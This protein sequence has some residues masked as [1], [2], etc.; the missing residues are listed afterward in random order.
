MR[1]VVLVI[2]SLFCFTTVYS[3]STG[4]NLAK[5]KEFLTTHTNMSSD[6]LL[7]QYDHG[8]FKAKISGKIAEAR[9]LDSVFIKYKMT[10]DE[11]G[12]LS[13]NGFTVTER[14]SYTNMV[15]AF[16]DVWAKDLP[17]FISTDAVLNAFHLSY[18]LIL[19]E[20]ELKFLIPK[21]EEFLN[22]LSANIGTLQKKYSSESKIIVS[23]KDLDIYLTVARKLLN[24]SYEP[25]FK[26]N[27]DLLIHLIDNVG[28]QTL[29]IEPLF[30]IADR[31]VDYSQF[32][33]R[34]HYTEQVQ[35]TKYFKTMMWLGRIEI[36]L[37]SP[38]EDKTSPTAFEDERRQIII[39]SLLGEL[40]Q[41][42]GAQQNYDEIEKIISSFVGEQDN[43]TL[44]QLN[45]LF[46][47]TKAQD[48][49]FFLK[50]ENV[51]LFQDY[52]STQPFAEQKIL[53]QVLSSDPLSPD[54][55]KP[56]S[57]FLF[58]GQRFVI[59][60][61]V[62]GNVV[63][64]K[65]LFNNQKITRLLPS[66]L[67]VLF[68]L[69]NSSVAQLLK[70]ELDKY[71]Y[72]TNL[73]SLR[74][75]VDSYGEDFWGLSIYNSWLNG[76]RSLNPPK[77]R[78]DLPEFMQTA[79][80]WQQKMNTQLAS[81]AE[82]RH[83]NIL[84]AKQ[85]YSSIVGCS[86]P[87]SYVEPIPQFFSAMKQIAKLALE[88][89]SSLSIDLTGPKFYFNS[90]YSTIDTLETIAKK[91]LDAVEFSK[92]EKKFLSSVV[93]TVQGGCTTTYDG[94]YVSKLIYPRGYISAESGTKYIVA[95]YH[96][97]PSDEA[98]NIVGWVKHAGTGPANLC[99]VVA[100]LPG[101]GDVAFAGPVSSYLEYTS[102][103]FL[104]LTDEEWRYKYIYYS[105]R[106]DWTNVYL[107]DVKGNK[108]NQ[109]S[110]LFTGINEK[111]GDNIIGNA[112]QLNVANYPNPFNPE[113]IIHF[114]IP[115]SI[116]GELVQ[117]NVFDIQGKQI[118][119]LVNDQLSSGNYLVK[120]E[121]KND[122]GNQV[123]SGVY[124][125]QLVV[126]KLNAVGKMNLI[127]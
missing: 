91:E 89:F 79:A 7:N 47:A 18:D 110:L 124:I 114:N 97:S 22:K 73:S 51:K 123:A 82:L 15:T 25:V 46:T 10:E 58:F 98:G 71:H 112:Y 53:S 72:S 3:Q 1:A 93:Y 17:V 99:V 117:L 87:Y 119:K 115:I 86:Y 103:D 41:T 105:T 106:P 44:N 100:K 62:T 69:G 8:K 64:D 35:L 29:I 59:D 31:S 49:L 92:E 57:A 19:K 81:W 80:Y 109:G 45:Q 121:G 96:T 102:N 70:S 85:S 75:L 43:I 9:Y 55:V 5:Y 39:S 116:S 52:L 76:L 6:E 26:E 95:D 94:W 127:K 50:D 36:Y 54:Q 30:S 78:A 28:K 2:F 4:F 48:A 32:K 34:G 68:S 12:L 60:S 77:D 120:W 84:Y 24:D 20:T 37:K 108:R 23:L 66:T 90:F 65:I 61:Y 113:T 13:K 88:K 40:I 11:K 38:I 63:Y 14:L 74:Y 21:L 27:N 125:Y 126:G 42:S 33:P 111:P 122:H 107:A 118:R 67:D 101:V 104:R 56:A 16:G 83:D